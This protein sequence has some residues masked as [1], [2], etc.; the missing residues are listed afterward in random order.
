MKATCWTSQG[1]KLE[2]ICITADGPEQKD[3]LQMALNDAAD[4]SSV[5]RRQTY[6]SDAGEGLYVDIIT[7]TQASANFL[8]LLRTYCRVCMISIEGG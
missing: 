3:L 6:S 4:I 8:A 5:H 1:S 2:I 7:D